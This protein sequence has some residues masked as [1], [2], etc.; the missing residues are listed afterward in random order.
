MNNLFNKY[1]PILLIISS[2]IIWKT[3]FSLLHFIILIII[4]I[5]IVS[6]NYVKGNKKI[7]I[8]SITTFIIVFSNLFFD[9]IITT[10]LKINFDRTYIY[11]QKQF[12]IVNVFHF[13]SIY[14]PYPI[15]KIVFGDWI[16]GVD[17]IKKFFSYFW[18]DNI[19]NT[20]GI[21]SI[22]PFIFGLLYHLNYYEGIIIFTGIIAGT[23]SRNPNTSTLFLLISP[24]LFYITIKGLHHF[25]KYQI[26]FIILINL[27]FSLTA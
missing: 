6:S 25:K 1:Y 2:P 18:I 23:I 13:K 3:K 26:F 20:I 12:D 16:I 15:R 7:L 4:T 21:A 8:L 11:D 14:L 10:K 5:S 22:L 27:L 17:I 24:A 19:I 9:Q